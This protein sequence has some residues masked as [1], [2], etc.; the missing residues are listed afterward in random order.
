ML[1]AEV[2]LDNDGQPARRLATYRDITEAHE[3]AA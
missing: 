1:A 3:A 2:S